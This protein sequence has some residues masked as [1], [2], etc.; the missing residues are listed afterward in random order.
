MTIVEVAPP[1]F[2]PPIRVRPVPCSE[3]PFDDEREPRVW[4]TANQLALDWPTP[5]PK[6]PARPRRPTRRADLLKPDRHPLGPGSPAVPPSP[7]GPPVGP[8]APSAQAPSAQTP[9]AQPPGGQ[10]N[11]AQ[12]HGAL[13]PR[14]Q[15]PGGQAAGGQAGRGLPP[16]VAGASGDAKLAVR[17]FVQ[18]C[19]EVL[20][21]YRPAAHLRRMALPKEASGVVAQAIAGTSRV[22]ELRRAGRHPGRRD[23]RPGPVGVVR[24]QLC[25]PRTGAVEAAVLLVTGERTW[26][27][28][29][30]LELHQESWFATTLRLI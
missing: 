18:M 28:A 30:R 1:G 29:L 10:G 27:M 13:V 8:Q 11:D 12:T 20:N 25:E 17:R 21:G 22:A 15:T 23:R 19:V 5:G 4:D 2:R 16:I 7:D 6:E 26:A 9:S 14:T 24:L 3:P